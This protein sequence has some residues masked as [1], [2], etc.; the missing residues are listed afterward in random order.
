MP[1]CSYGRLSTLICLRL[2]TL[3]AFALQ[4]Q[5]GGAVTVAHAEEVAEQLYPGRYVAVCKPMPIFGC[6][7]ETDSP[8]QVVPFPQLTSEVGDHIDRIPRD[9]EYS[10]MIDW[11]RRACAY[12]GT[13]EGQ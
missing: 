9:G 10:R 2:C 12:E 6:V 13:N 5:A 8:G 1:K 11:M 4:L 3:L 7:C